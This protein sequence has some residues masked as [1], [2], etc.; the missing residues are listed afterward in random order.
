MHLFR[1]IA[2]IPVFLYQKI[3]SPVLPSSC[4]YYP[5][6]SE[7]TRQAILRHGIFRGTVMGLM[8]IGRCSSRFYGGTDT[9]PDYFSLRELRR[10][11]RERSVRRVL[12]EKR[13]RER[14]D[15]G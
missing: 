11:Y 8:R 14:S 7:Y 15:G 4:N 9:V 2:V 10:E 3:V 6:C 5:T 13:T 1:Y 12:R